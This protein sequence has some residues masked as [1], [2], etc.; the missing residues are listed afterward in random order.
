[1]FEKKYKFIIILLIFLF[2]ISTTLSAMTKQFAS[3]PVKDNDTY[4][5][6]N[7]TTPLTKIANPETKKIDSKSLNFTSPSISEDLKNY[8]VDNIK[9]PDGYVLTFS[10]SYN[11]Q[12]TIAEIHLVSVDENDYHD[13]NDYYAARVYGDVCKREG[14]NEKQIYIMRDSRVS[15]LGID[16]INNTKDGIYLLKVYNCI[17]KIGISHSI[18]IPYDQY[19]KYKSIGGMYYKG[20]VYIP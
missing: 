8:L 3:L 14:L 15:N 19:S 10:F 11:K 5:D 4:V 7:I 6:E 20:K 1:M 13:G 12:G 16:W 17:K 2:L 18:K 9:F